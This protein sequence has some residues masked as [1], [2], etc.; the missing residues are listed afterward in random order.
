MNI[1]LLEPKTHKAKA[2]QIFMFSLLWILMEKGLKFMTKPKWMFWE[3]QFINPSTC[4]LI[5]PKGTL[6]RDESGKKQKQNFFH[7]QEKSHSIFFWKRP[8]RIWSELTL[9]QWIPS[10]PN[11]GA[12]FK[13]CA[14]FSFISNWNQIAIRCKIGSLKVLSNSYGKTLRSDYMY[15]VKLHSWR[16]C[17]KIQRALVIPSQLVWTVFDVVQHCAQTKQDRAEKSK[18]RQQRSLSLNWPKF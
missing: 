7:V 11:L 1:Y 14:I 18:P 16:F 9:T 12:K 17:E 3:K 13:I 5:L 6:F 4:L 8:Q 2:L 15:S 10:A